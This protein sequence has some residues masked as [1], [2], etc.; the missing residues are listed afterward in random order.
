ML[1]VKASFTEMLDHCD[2]LIRLILA[3]SLLMVQL[4][5]WEN[6]CMLGNFAFI[7]LSRTS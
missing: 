3:K 5:S 7:L 1:C 4:S 6:L 2:V